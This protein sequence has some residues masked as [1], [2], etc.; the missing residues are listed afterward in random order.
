MKYLDRNFP[1]LKNNKDNYVDNPLMLAVM[2]TNVTT[3]KVILE[4]FGREP[5]ETDKFGRNSF[6][7]SLVFWLLLFKV[8]LY[9]LFL[10]N[11]RCVVDCRFYWLD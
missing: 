3:V 1:H 4:K 9:F 11:F 10:L 7:T 2:K 5:Q 8:S 6:L